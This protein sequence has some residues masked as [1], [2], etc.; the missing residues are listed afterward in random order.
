MRCLCPTTQPTIWW[1]GALASGW[2][3][4]VPVL[5]GPEALEASPRPREA[6]R[7]LGPA[8]A[9]PADWY[10]LSPDRRD[11]CAPGWS[12]W[13]QHSTSLHEAVPAIQEVS[14]EMALQAP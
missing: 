11:K 4:T 12:I 7:R 8:P 1:G 10:Q 13:P 9:I 2:N 3:E 14:A 6:K 5:G